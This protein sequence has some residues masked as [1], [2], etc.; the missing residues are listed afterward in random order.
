[1]RRRGLVSNLYR[2]ARLANDVSVLTSGN[3]HRMARRAKN[4]IVGRAMARAGVW[5]MLWGH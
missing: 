4:K 5:R 2:A 3:P 1:M